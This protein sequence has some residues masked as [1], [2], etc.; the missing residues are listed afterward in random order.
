M[1]VEETN[2][3]V[4]SVEDKPSGIDN[5]DDA[6]KVI[7]SLRKENAAKRVKT[8]DV[9]DKA[10]R[11]EEY[12]ESQKTEMEKLT[13]SNATLSKEN[14]D[15]KFSITRDKIA[16]EEGVPEDLLEF[17]VGTDENTLRAK[18]KKLAASAGSKDS[19][20]GKQDFFAGQRGKPVTP[21]TEGLNDWFTQMWRDVD[22]KNSRTTMTW[23][24]D[25]S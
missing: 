5:L 17:L 13:E 12:V 15:L 8:K 25:E 10:K 21:V 19:G 6:L 18:A 14:D 4:E 23:A 11:W 20:E 3:E 1:S 7:E 24:N 2:E 22:A 16:R 9:E